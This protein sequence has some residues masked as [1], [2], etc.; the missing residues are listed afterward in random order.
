M[1]KSGL[2]DTGILDIMHD[3]IYF[4]DLERNITY[5]N[6]GAE[7]ISGFSRDEVIGKS[8]A[9]NI[10]I[11]V[12]ASGRQ[13]CNVACPVNATMQ[14]CMEREANVFLHHK[15]G[16]RVP[17]TVR[18]VP[19]L[20]DSG[21]VSGAAE[22]FW[23]NSE[24][25]M[26]AGFIEELKKAA[27]FDHLT[28][29][30]NRRYLE[31]RLKIAFDEMKR[32]G[33]LFGLIFTDIDH[34]KK[35][36]DKYGHEVGDNIL[37]MV[38]STLGSN[39]RSS[40]L[41]GRWGGEEFILVIKHLKKPLHINSTAEKLRMLVEESGFNFNGEIIKATITMGAAVVKKGDTQEILIKRADGLLYSGKESGRNRV[42][43]E[44]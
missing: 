17:V 42:V 5:W 40:D 13:L 16:H 34:F 26:D 27:L 37:K 23:D 22:I 39:L 19:F 11:H 28:G 41:I 1:I 30:P 20:D 24:K 7:D 21:R 35:I 12:D 32:Y 38:S 36:N 4:I 14:D 9:D 6:K 25:V 18:T 43:F 3:G 8:C 29:L 31:M 15:K 44:P 33:F 10:L 2:V